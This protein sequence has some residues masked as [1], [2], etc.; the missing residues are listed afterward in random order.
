LGP[1]LLENSALVGNSSLDE[2]EQQSAEAAGRG[3]LLGLATKGQISGSMST[4]GE[5]AAERL[6]VRQAA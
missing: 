1:I 5:T 2:E 3:L 6:G 4:G